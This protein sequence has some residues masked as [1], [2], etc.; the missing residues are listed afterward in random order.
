MKKYIITSLF[1]VVLLSACL[2]EDQTLSP[3]DSNPVIEIYNEFPHKIASTVQSR[4]P[5]YIESFSAVP[6]QTQNFDLYVSYSGAESAPEDISVTLTLDQATLDIYNE[7]W[8]KDFEI[9]PSNLYTGGELNVVIKKGEKR[10][11]TTFVLKTSEF[12]FNKSYALPVKISQVSKGI[13]SGNNGATV[14]SIV[15]KNKY[16]GVYTL[17]SRLVPAADRATQASGQGFTIS[18]AIYM[19]TVDVNSVVLFDNNTFKDYIHPFKTPTGM[20]GYGSFSP[21]F[22]FDAAGN[23]TNVRNWYTS[24]SNGR[25]ATFNTDVTDNRYD[26]ANR[27]I[28]AAFI[29]NQPGWAPLPIYDTLVFVEERP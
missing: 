10:A 28:Y 22:T 3:K 26:E 18:N 7:Q 13:I 2:K 20:S 4:V 21:V 6:G 19:V 15:P 11:K 5:L 25:T 16:D 9:L 14:F 8:D 1:A 24:P 27:T 17:R 12:D 23:M 29:M